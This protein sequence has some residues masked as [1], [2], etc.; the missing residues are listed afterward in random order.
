MNY[1]L[2]QLRRVAPA[3]MVLVAITF[4]F[5]PAGAEAAV[6]N[7]LSFQG[8]LL[9]GPTTPAANVTVQIRHSMWAGADFVDGVDRDGSGALVG[10]P[11]EEVQT[12][13][14]DAQGFFMTIV[15]S[16]TALPTVFD[17]NLHQYLQ[18]EVKANGSADTTYFLL[19]NMTA[20]NAIDRK[21]ITASVYAQN[22]AR[23]DGRELG[24]GNGDIPY[25]DDV[26]GLLNHELLTDSS[27]RAPV[28]DLAAMAALTDMVD[29]TV[30]F[31]VAEERMYTYDLGGTTWIRTG[32]DSEGD[33][34][35]LEGRMDTAETNITT[36]AANIAT[37]VTNISTNAT[38]IAAEQ[39]RAEAAESTLTTN[40]ANEV[41]RATAAEGVNA[42]NI[43]SNDGELATLNADVDTAGSVLNSVR[44]NA[45]NATFSSSTGLSSTTLGTAIDEVHTAIDSLA[46]GTNWKAAVTDFADLATTY[47]AAVIGD[48]AYVTA[49][50]EIYTY[51]G[52][53]WV[54]TGADFFQDGT[55]ADKGIVQFASDRE[56][57]A[58][59][60]VQA[61]DGR[62][63]DIV[64]NATNITTNAAN[65]TTNATAVATEQAR[66]E[67]AEAANAAN[68]TTNT[69][70][71]AAEITRATAAEDANA[72]DIAEHRD[73][74]SVGFDVFVINF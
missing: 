33:I 23:L 8:R 26:T 12:I 9:T 69:D 24:F 16:V 49:L 34:T 70:G 57:V 59:K 7:T 42:T 28:A 10:A 40:L 4:S 68:I 6:A 19:D 17:S 30:V 63:D 29:G 66:A 13:T 52:A 1:I 21:S 47:P 44:E 58:L 46:S 27:W 74:N 61:N 35:A 62:F 53:A 67:A 14:T 18:A 56:D 38:A 72:A 43:T 39:T 48:T 37:N 25:L 31:V 2:K 55:E 64:T 36:N 50:G 41:T 65:I 11:W 3:A 5:M 71:L 73:F 20:N 54:K 51:D 15:G 60:A 22:A 32:G 45:T